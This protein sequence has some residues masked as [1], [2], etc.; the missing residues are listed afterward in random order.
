MLYVYAY[1]YAVLYLNK[2][3]THSYVSA[4]FTI[5]VYTLSATDQLFL[6]KFGAL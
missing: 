5:L 4:L 1:S 2:A 6:N 3:D